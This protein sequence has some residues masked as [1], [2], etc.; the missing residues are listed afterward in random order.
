MDVIGESGDAEDG[1]GD[2]DREEE[3]SGPAEEFGTRLGIVL[4][5]ILTVWAFVGPASLFELFRY[6]LPIVASFR[7]PIPNAFFGYMG[8]ITLLFAIVGAIAFPLR[9]PNEAMDYVE[10]DELSGYESDFA[11]GL[12]I[13]VAAI[14]VV[15]AVL[16][17]VFPALYYAVTGEFVRAGTILLGVIIMIAIAYLLSWIAILI[18][19]VASLPVVIPSFVGSYLGGFVRKIAGFGPDPASATHRYD[20]PDQRD[21]R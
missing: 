1:D 16:G 12:V 11:I 17:F 14:A 4:G 3:E 18:V 6:E 9:R 5:L 8:G 21:E 19:G 10:S 20:T 2:T 7:D 13:P 15:I